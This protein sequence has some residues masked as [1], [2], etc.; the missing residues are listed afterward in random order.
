MASKKPEPIASFRQL[1]L[2]DLDG[3]VGGARKDKDQQSQSGPA[4]AA[5]DAS[6]L[7]NVV[8]LTEAQVSAIPPAEFAKLTGDQL[9]SFS[10]GQLNDVSGAQL[11]T[12][13]ESQLQSIGRDISGVPA[14]ALAAVTHFSYLTDQQLGALTST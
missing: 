6:W 11:N 4:Q 13:S 14:S 9:T 1:S 7:L 10:A 2:D 12:L 8:I 5:F 3:I